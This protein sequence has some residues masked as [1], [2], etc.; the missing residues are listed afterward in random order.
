MQSD[1]VGLEA[2]INT[3]SYVLSDPLRNFD[4]DGRDVQNFRTNRSSPPNEDVMRGLEC[5]SKCLKA[6]IWLSSGHRDLQS[7]RDVGG[8]PDS[9]HL[10]GLAADVRTPPSKS[11]LRKAAAECGFFVLPTDYKVHIH[12]D[13]RGGRSPKSDPDECVCAGIRQGP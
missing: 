10:E 12:I 9:Y 13:L 2:G 4:P 3:Y 7:N 6:T 8:E 1:P 5:M 11:K